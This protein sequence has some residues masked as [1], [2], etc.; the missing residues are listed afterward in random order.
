MVALASLSVGGFFGFLFGMPRAV[1]ASQ[2]KEEP[3]KKA[4]QASGQVSSL[5]QAKTRPNTNLEEISD[6]LTKILVGAGL[7]QLNKIQTKLAELSGYVASG[8]GGS[9]ADKSLVAVEIVFFG[10]CGFLGAFLW[11]RLYMG[12]AIQRA[13]EIQAVKKAL[14]ETGQKLKQTDEKQQREIEQ[15][16]ETVKQLAQVGADEAMEDPL[17]SERVAKTQKAQMDVAARFVQGEPESARGAKDFLILAYSD[18]Q[19]ENFKRAVENA[20]RAL[21]ANPSKDMLWKIYNLL[22]LCYHWQEPEN[23]KPGGDMTWFDKAIR[24]YE[25]AIKNRNTLAEELLSKANSSFVYLDAER[26]LE[27]EQKAQEVIAS[28][29]AG[30]V[31]VAQICDLARI[32]AAAAKVMRGDN[33]GAEAILNSTRDIASFAYLFN[34]DDLPAAAITGFAASPGLRDEVK[35]FVVR[36]AKSL[37][38]IS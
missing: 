35:A 6:W 28:E 31:K 11:V 34:T 30:G 26:Y 23:W 13:D 14:Q 37:N 8:M 20:E 22:G 10:V 1:V 16:K 24:N 21:G 25:L 33:T 36:V 18:F 19:K 12:K 15:A 2:T 32:A 5:N 27:C 38:L 7:T 29:Q 17:L 9:G 4:E 3:D